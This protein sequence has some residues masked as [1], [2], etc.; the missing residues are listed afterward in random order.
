MNIE[1]FAFS[2]LIA[3][4]LTYMYSVYVV[5]LSSLPQSEIKTW[6]FLT[7]LLLWPLY[8]VLVVAAHL[9][10]IFKK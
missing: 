8:F 4:F 10:M 2:W 9:M 7:M 3:G 5:S 6:E 1:V